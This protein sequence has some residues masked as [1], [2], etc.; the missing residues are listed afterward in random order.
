MKKEIYERKKRKE[1][2]TSSQRN[3]SHARTHTFCRSYNIY[4]HKIYV[5]TYI[6]SLSFSLNP[7]IDRPHRDRNAE[8][9][10]AEAEFGF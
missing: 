4:I 7:S 6:I 10:I 9:I 8:I 1:Q 3:T 2:N 5:Y